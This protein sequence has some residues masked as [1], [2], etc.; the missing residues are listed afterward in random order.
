MPKQSRFP[1]HINPIDTAIDFCLLEPTDLPSLE[2]RTITPNFI[3]DFSN[4]ATVIPTEKP[5]DSL[6]RAE[7]R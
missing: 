2:A 7:S 5:S 3:S 4:I 6:P 1:N